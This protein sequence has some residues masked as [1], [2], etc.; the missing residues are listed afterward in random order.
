MEKKKIGLQRPPEGGACFAWIGGGGE[1]SGKFTK[2]ATGVYGVSEGEH[3][4]LHDP[5]GWEWG[6]AHEKNLF[7]FT[8]PGVIIDNWGR[9]LFHRGTFI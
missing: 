4:T 6:N 5:Q 9:G 3:K 7:E 1:E 8:G 2:F